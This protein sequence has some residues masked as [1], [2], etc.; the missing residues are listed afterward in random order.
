MTKQLCVASVAL[1]GLCLTSS[2]VRGDTVL[3][4]SPNI[5]YSD[6]ARVTL[7]ASQA[8]FDRIINDDPIYNL[9]YDNPG[10]RVRFRTDATSITADLDYNGLHASGSAIEGTGVILRDGQPVGTFTSSSPLRGHYCYVTQPA[11]GRNARLPARHALRRFGG[12]QATECEHRRVFRRSPPA[13][14]DPLRCLRR[15]DHSGLLCH[16]CFRTTTA[17]LLGAS[18][19]TLRR[20]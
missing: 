18:A 16:R 3:A 20:R 15:L 17:S 8:S 13:A 11:D 6:V 2:N 19:K 5:Q 9:R 12:F 7:S 14:G 10:A 1:G 4:D